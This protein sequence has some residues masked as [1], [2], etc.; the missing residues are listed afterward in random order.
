MSNSGHLGHLGHKG[1]DILENIMTTPLTQG[2][3]QLAGVNEENIKI[4]ENG[5]K[6]DFTNSLKANQCMV[7]RYQDNI[8]IEFRKK[9]SNLLQGTLDELV[10]EEVI[11]ESEFKDYFEKVTGIYLNALM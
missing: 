6:F 1:I 8:I 5:F 7:V 10:F 4:L 3:K 9:T 2:L 11:K